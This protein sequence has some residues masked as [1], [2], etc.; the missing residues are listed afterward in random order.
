MPVRDQELALRQRGAHGAGPARIGD[1]AQPVSL[2][3]VPE[4]EHLAGGRRFQQP[5]EVLGQ[6]PERLEAHPGGAHEGEAVLLGAPV[7]PLVGE[8]N[9][10]LVRLQA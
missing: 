6:E 10:V 8:H 2:A 5:P 4:V 9:P 1:R 7:R 3:G